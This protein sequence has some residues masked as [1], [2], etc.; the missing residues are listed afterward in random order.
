MLNEDEFSDDVIPVQT[1]KA[2]QSTEAGQSTAG[3]ERVQG[4]LARYEYLEAGSFA[5]GRLD[6][7]TSTALRKYQE[8]FGLDETLSRS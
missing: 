7:S 8:F 5:S 1:A 4:F 2:G 6:P 3:L